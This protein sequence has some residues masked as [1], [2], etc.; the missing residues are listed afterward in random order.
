M[1]LCTKQTDNKLWAKIYLPASHR[2]NFLIKTAISMATTVLKYT[3]QFQRKQA[4]SMAT[5]VLKYT[6]QFQRKLALEQTTVCL[7]SLPLQEYKPHFIA[8][9]KT[10]ILFL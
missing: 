5:T 1:S 7:V 8:I 4:I 10:I 6:V 2:Q 3:V 9:W